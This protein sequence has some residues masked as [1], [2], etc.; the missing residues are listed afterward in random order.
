MRSSG[1]Y[2]KLKEFDNHKMVIYIYN[3]CSKLRGFIAIHRGGAILPT[4]GATRIWKY[5]NETEVLKDALRL[6]RLMSYKSALAGL[7]YGGAKA[8]LLDSSASKKEKDLLIKTYAQRINF[9]DGR[10]ITGADVGVDDN[11]LKIMAR[12]SKYIVGQ[13]NDAVKYTV[14][15][16]LY[17]IQ[18]CLKE[19]FGSENLDSRTI[20]IQGLGKTGA[21]LLKL[22]YG[23]TKKIYIAEV[24]KKKVNSIKNKYPKVEI[25]DPSVIHKLDVDIFS[26]CALSHIINYK[27]ISSIRSKIIAGSANNQ[28]CDLELGKLLYKLNILYA[29]DYVINAGGLISVV[30]EYENKDSNE[31]R[32]ENK[33]IKI[34]STLKSIIETSKKTHKSTN[35]VADEMAEKIFNKFV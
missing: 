14:L 4:F 3:E 24:D 1:F 8:V 17:S 20:A 15:G 32:I 18:V 5:S 9:L 33:V 26:P 21:G 6:S 7:K 35:L 30:D 23:K 25:V 12:E 22:V 19:I 2:E 27:S 28:L 10:F 29:P 16:V 31:K 13:K 11:E 34:K